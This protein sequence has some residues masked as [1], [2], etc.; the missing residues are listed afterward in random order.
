MYVTPLW[1]T[2]RTVWDGERVGTGKH[3]SDPL[4]EKLE[5]DVSLNG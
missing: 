3:S 1:L 4:G 5:L 2:G